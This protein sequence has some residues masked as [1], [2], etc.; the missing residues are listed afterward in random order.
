[1]KWMYS[2]GNKTVASGALLS[3]CLLVLFS[4]YIDRDHTSNVKKSIT[5]LYEDRLVA[6]AYILKMTS[7]IYQIK[8]ILNA[9][10]QKR[11]NVDCRI[12][13]F[14]LVIMDA[15]LAYVNTLITGFDQVLSAVLV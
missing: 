13:I 6:E 12:S 1:M 14:L 8:E 5:T 9:S 10:D 3:L 7:D 2:V 15:S 4:N 11:H